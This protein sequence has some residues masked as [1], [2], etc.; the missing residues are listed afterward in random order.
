MI[1]EEYRALELDV[2]LFE[3]DYVIEASPKSTPKVTD[4]DMGEWVK[5]A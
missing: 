2:I 5:P 3:L 4:P 1:R